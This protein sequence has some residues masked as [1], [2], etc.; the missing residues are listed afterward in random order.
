MKLLVKKK[1]EA[2]QKRLK[3][4]MPT[5]HYRKYSSRLERIAHIVNDN[6]VRLEDGVKYGGISKKSLEHAVKAIKNG[7]PI[8]KVGH[9]PIISGEKEKQFLEEVTIESR[10]GTSLTLRKARDLMENIINDS[11]EEGENEEKIKK[12]VTLKTVHAFIK[13]H[14]ELKSS[15]PK[16]VDINRLAASCQKVL[17]PWYTELQALHDENKYPEE[18]IFN[19]DESSLR[20]PTSTRGI[21]VHPADEQAGFKKTAERMP[22]ATLVA[23]IAADGFSLPSVVLWPSA[24]LPKELTTLLTPS[25]DIWPNTNGWM[26]KTAFKKYTLTVLLPAIIDRRKRILKETH[27]CLLLL[28]S[29]SSRADPTI[30]RQF[31]EA[32]IDVVTFVPHTTHISK[33]LDRGV[34]AVLKSEL[35][36]NYSSPSS[37]YSSS[38]RT[39]VADVLPQ[40]L[41]TAF[42][43][44]VIKKTFINSGVLSNGSGSV[45]MKLPQSSQY[46]IPSHSHCFDFF[47]KEITKEKLL[48][49]WDEYNEKHKMKIEETEEKEKEIEEEELPLEKKVKRKFRKIKND[50]DETSDEF[51]TFERENGKRK[52]RRVIDSSFVF[53]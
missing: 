15:L 12:T 25:L 34:F 40:A 11:E 53:F 22:N 35:S 42:T 7:R 50:D 26:D 51:D 29:H 39:A 21:V 46:F 33:P 48:D 4:A 32:E 41:H 1:A 20:I 27:R 31:K 9:P 30:W 13:R 17:K 3:E 18:L 38:K 49:E 47:G 28:D 37:T 44:S 6:V 8:A 16:Q 2:A 5:L 19:I 14:P 52:V 23:G 36:N 10:S 45:L 24:N 43:P